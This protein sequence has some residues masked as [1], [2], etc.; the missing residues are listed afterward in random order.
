R[1]GRRAKKTKAAIKVASLNIRGYGNPNTAH[2]E[3]KW[4]FINQLMPLLMRTKRLGVLLVQEAHMDEEQRSDVNKRFS[5]RIKVFSS[6]HPESPHSKEG[7]AIV[8]NKD[9]LETDDNLIG[10]VTIVP[11]RALWI[12][13]NWHMNRKLKILVVYAPNVSNSSGEENA[14]FWK[15]L[16][17]FFEQYPNRKPDIMA[18]D[19]N[20]V[21]TG[22][23]DRLPAHDDPDEAME[24]LDDL[25]ILLNLQDGWRDTYPDQKSYTFHQ[26]ATGSQSRLDRIY[27]TEAILSASREWKIEPSGFPNADHKM[28]SVLASCEEAPEVGRGRWVIPGHLLKDKQLRQFAHQRGMQAL[29]VLEEVDQLGRSS[30]RNAQLAWYNY[31]M[32]LLVEAQRHQKIIVPR[33]EKQLKELEEKLAAVNNDNTLNEV[34]KTNQAAILTTEITTLER[35]RFQETRKATATKNR[36]E[37]EQI[38]RYWSNL[39]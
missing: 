18:G 28:V 22:L 16:Y 31:K 39:N 26:T 27:T 32:D 20:M 10:Y 14:E 33:T 17:S 4:N 25:K 30:E 5:K 6:G 36:V 24:A 13:I 3:N 23:I 38:S 12:K 34:E 21:E 35:K 8:L 2:P 7:V 19:M 1:T 15:K 9:F 37:G 29:N 11:G